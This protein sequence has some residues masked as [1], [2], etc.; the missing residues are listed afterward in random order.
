MLAFAPNVH[1]VIGAPGAL[2]GDLPVLLSPNLR[3][4]PAL[5]AAIASLIGT[6]A[7]SGILKL[8]TGVTPAEWGTTHADALID[9]V[10]HN[11]CEPWVAATLIGPSATSV[12]LLLH[13]HA[14]AHAI[15]R[16]RQANPD[17]P[18][19]WMHVLPHPDRDRLLDALRACLDAAARCLLW[20]PTKCAERLVGEI[21]TWWIIPTLDAYIDAAPIAHTRHAAILIEKKHNY[22][23]WER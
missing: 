19:V 10:H 20:L 22:C 18:T 11:R 1:P 4:S 2:A 13:G 14:I 5:H 6:K 7:G 3:D 16:W 17:D 8:W 9:T 23:V 15:Q 21:R 12:A